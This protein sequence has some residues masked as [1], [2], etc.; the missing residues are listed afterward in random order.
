[1][2]RP[3]FNSVQA[4]QAAQQLWQCRQTHTRVTLP[5][6]LVPQTLNESYAIQ[7]AV[8]S[9]LGK[10]V[11]GYKIGLT[12]PATWAGAGVTEPIS[13]RVFADTILSNRITAAPALSH[14]RAVESEIAFTLGTTFNPRETPYSLAEVIAGISKTNACIEICDSRYDSDDVSLAC[15]VADNANGAALVL[16]DSLDKWNIDDFNAMPVTLY[17]NNEVAVEGTTRN[18]MGNPLNA[19]LWQI[20]WLSA[21]KIP[22]HAGQVVSTGTCTGVTEGAAGDHFLARFGNTFSVEFTFGR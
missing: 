6:E 22:V 17:R 11:V 10:P 9:L 21:R 4:D 14:L 12:N 3:T 13:G 1:M 18:V 8:T 5:A 20:N 19:L 16:G 7:D 2:T 15:I